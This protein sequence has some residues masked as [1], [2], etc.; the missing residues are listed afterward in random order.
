M[1]YLFTIKNENG[2]AVLYRS[3]FSIFFQK[4]LSHYEMK[5]KFLFDLLCFEINQFLCVKKNPTHFIASF[6]FASFWLCSFVCFLI[7][8]P[9][10]K[11]FTVSLTWSSC[12]LVTSAAPHGPLKYQTNSILRQ[13]HRL[14]NVPQIQARRQNGGNGTSFQSSRHSRCY[15][16]FFNL[17]V[18]HEEKLLKEK[19]LWGSLK[20]KVLIMD[21]VRR[22]LEKLL[23][24]FYEAKKGSE[25]LP[26]KM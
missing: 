26:F 7:F 22:S 1:L 25:T 6:F 12:V 15:C 17:R 21:G 4:N 8:N 24:G 18:R 23:F 19:D 13:P 9:V 20:E 3:V 10:C 5:F 16:Y 14:I 11:C 2:N